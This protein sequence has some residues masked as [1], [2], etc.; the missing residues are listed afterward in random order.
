MFCWRSFFVFWRAEKHV[1]LFAPFRS[2][3]YELKSFGCLEVWNRV[4]NW[5]KGKKLILVGSILQIGQLD[6]PVFSCK[7]MCQNS[8]WI[9]DPHGI[10]EFNRVANWNKGKNIILVRSLFQ[11]CDQN[12]LISNL[13]LLMSNINMSVTNNNFEGNIS[14]YVIG[15]S[16]WYFRGNEI[17]CQASLHL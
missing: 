4:S 6:V 7:L 16:S 12:I 13:T 3:S 5:N 10:Y 9:S 11:K 15:K 17:D 8:L 14:T 2:T 1:F